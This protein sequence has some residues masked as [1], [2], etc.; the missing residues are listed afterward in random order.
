[1][2]EI[3]FRAWL[4]QSG[5]SDEP[6]IGMLTFEQLRSRYEGEMTDMFGDLD[7]KLMQ[8]TGLKDKS[9]KEIYEGDIVKEES[10]DFW[11]IEFGKLPLGKAGD[12]VCTYRAFYAKALHEHRQQYD[13][14]EP[15]EWQ[16]V[17]GNI[18]ENKELLK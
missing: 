4:D 17:I 10:G 1:M 11:I 18:Y 9:G 14:I 13:C 2:R 15:A 8:Y 7:I 3:K 6:E 16:E 5:W 12:C